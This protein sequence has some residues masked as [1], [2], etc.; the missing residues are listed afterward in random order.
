M[1]LKSSIKLTQ[2]NAQTLTCYIFCILGLV[3][4]TDGCLGMPDANLFEFLLSQL[5]ASTISCSFMRIGE[6]KSP[7]GHFGHVSHIEL[8]Q[9]VATATFGSYFDCCPDIVMPPI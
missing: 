3:I 7:F 9:F 2:E 5:R 6:S 8:M 4:I 1:I